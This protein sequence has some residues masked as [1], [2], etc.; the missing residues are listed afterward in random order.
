[1]KKADWSKDPSI[2]REYVSL[3]MADGFRPSTIEQG[4]QILL[5]YDRFL[6]QHLSIALED[7]G[8]REFGA[9]KANLAQQSVSRATARGYLSYVT[10]FY[11]LRAQASQDSELLETYSK[12]KAI[13]VPRKAKSR[14]WKSL[15]LETVRKILEA[16]KRYETIRCGAREAPSEDYVFL[17]T[18]LYTGGRAQFYGLRV[19][20]LDF[21]KKEITT[22]VKGGKIAT[23]PLHPTLAQVLKEHLQTRDYDS[24]YLFRNGSDVTTRKGQKANRQNAWRACKRAQAAVGI[25]E[26]IHPHR[27][28]KTLATYGKQMGMDPQFLQA[29]LAHESVNMTLDEYA[30]VELEDVKREFAKL[31]LVNGRFEGNETEPKLTVLL[32]RLRK[33]APR[34]K[35]RAW[36]LF[37]EGLVGLV[38]EGQ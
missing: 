38:E 33:M 27:F 7:A 18:L 22:V 13:G 3:A 14:K 29:I 9:Y 16:T 11:R 12:I 4:R 1:M 26:S 32:N 28:R 5:R 37:I 36:N 19:K 23:I 8:W 35:E 10:G 2:I 15:D 17:M 20:D 34:G 30:Q 6:R 24:E 21:E 31:D 25:H